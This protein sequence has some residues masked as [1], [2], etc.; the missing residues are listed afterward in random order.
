MAVSKLRP[1]RGSN[2]AGVLQRKCACGGSS[3]SGAEC[4]ECSAKK[5]LGLQAKLTV[6]QPGD[7]YEQE[8]DRVADEVM[9]SPTPSAVHGAPARI[10]RAARHTGLHNHSAPSSATHIQAG[11]ARPLE[12][13]LRQ[14]MEQRF[15]YDFSQVRL[16]VGGAAEQS[17]R[18]VDADAYTIGHDIVFGA[19]QFAPQTGKGRRLIAHELTHVVQQSGGVVARNA[20]LQ[21]QPSHQNETMSQYEQK[22]KQGTWCRDSE[23]TGALHDPNQQCYRELV[24]NFDEEAGQVC[25]DKKT[26]KFADSSPDF[27]SAVS[28]INKDGTCDIPLGLFDPPN[29]FTKRGQR[30][31]GHGIA[32]VCGEDPGMCGKYFGRV[33]GVAMGIALPKGDTNFLGQIA[34][35]V[36][37]GQLGGWLASKQLPKLDKL[38]RRHGFLPTLSLGLGSNLGLSVGTGFEKRDRPLPLIPINTY[39][40]FSLDSSLAAKGESAFLAKVGVRI[41]PGKQGG[42]FAL[43]SLGAGL[44]TGGTDVSGT[45]SA[46][47][48]VGFRA[49]DF[50]D[51]QIVHETLTGGEGGGGGTYW[52]TLKLVAPKRVLEGHKK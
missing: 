27:I 3:A 38:A 24:K 39:L 51:V 52:L 45:V 47:V 32:D 40:T 26:G 7:A 29:P 42:I 30:A 8:A 10:Q 13:V 44:A 50:L 5:R 15:G 12:P 25:F 22:V 35:P 6:S 28:G 31:L 20:V 18:D 41:D 2:R 49:R 37:L 11:H 34:V 48:G 1:I 14:D 36:V 43:G 16:H 4:E 9:R 46:D 17:A 23:K 33:A 21:R 19:G